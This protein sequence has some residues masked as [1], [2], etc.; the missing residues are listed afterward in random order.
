V[1]TVPT[2]AG[3]DPARFREI[4]L[5]APALKTDPR[6]IFAE[7]LRDG[8]FYAAIS[9]TPSAVLTRYRDVADA[10]A[11]HDRL[12]NEKLRLPGWEKLDYFNGELNI[13]FSDAPVHDRLRKTLAPPL[14]PTA[15]RALEERVTHVAETLLDRIDGDQFEAMTQ[16]AQPASRTAILGELLGLPEADFDIF[17]KLTEAMFGLGDLALGSA[18][19]PAYTAAW[20][21]ALDYI[22]VVVAREHV[23]PSRGIVSQL[24]RAHREGVLSR[25]EM[26]AQFVTVYAGG[27]SPISTLIGSTLLMLARH[28]DQ[29]RALRNKPAMLDAAL[30]EVLRFHSPGL[31]NF[32]FARHDFELNGLPILKDMPVYM[33]GHAANFDGE[34][35]DRPFEFNIMRVRKPLLAFGRGVHFCIGFHAARMV[36]RKVLGALFNRFESFELS[37]AEPIR[38]TGNPQERAPLAVPLAVRRSGENAA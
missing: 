17:I 3:L 19:P 7:W 10:F 27:T 32:R 18:H 1:S 8:S 9:G 37:E 13:A 16:F 21:G 11:D 2:V 22:D 30:D 24:V 5:F 35:Y 26:V 14:L 33:I 23:S 4:D 38:Y 25:G 29:Q 20:A 6:P 34:V 36:T 12:S 31:F 15:I 28:P